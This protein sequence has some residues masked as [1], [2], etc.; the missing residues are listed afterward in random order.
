MT[1]TQP[2]R[3]RTIEV[4]G[5]GDSI[6][7][8]TATTADGTTLRTRDYYMRRNLALIFTH[9][10]DCADCR[11]LL[12]RVARQ[13]G[14]ARQEAGEVIAVI[15]ADAT[16]VAKLRDELDLSFPLVID[17]D[18][19][20][21]RRYGLVSPDGAPMAAIIVTDQFGTI[22]DTSVADAEHQ[23][24]TAEEIPGWLEFVACQC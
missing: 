4:P 20:I 16:T 6:P 13:H 5:R 8:F 1:T 7:D 12:R 9:G 14:A 23:M 18:L 21:H 24:M 10:A 11:E 3:T 17:E 22:F 15:P 2:D 19:A